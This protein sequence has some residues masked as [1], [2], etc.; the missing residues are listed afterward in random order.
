M[1]SR[2]LSGYD[3]EWLQTISLSGLQALA[4]AHGLEDEAETVPELIELLAREDDNEYDEFDEKAE[5]F[6]GSSPVRG[7]PPVK[8][9][10]DG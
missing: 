1:P 9:S 6:S 8:V 4:K 3:L 10:A 2:R 7:R 5:F